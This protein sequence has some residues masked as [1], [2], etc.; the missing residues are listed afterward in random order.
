MKITTVFVTHDQE[1]AL[2]ISD[3]VF[4]MD[5][6][7]LQ[8]IGK[9]MQIYEEPANMFVA[10]FIGTPNINFLEAKISYGHLI[11]QGSQILKI[12]ERIENYDRVILGIR[13]EHLALTKINEHY[14]HLGIGKISLI[15]HLGKINNVK[16]Q[17]GVNELTVLVEPEQLASHQVGDEIMLYFLKNKA[18]LFG[19][20]ENRIQVSYE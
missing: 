1:E 12:K 9:P 17:L 13:P 10:R 7:S 14:Q 5:K 3:K 16:V 2:S 19:Q 20:D 6:G 15:E 11:F 18:Y 4:V 8:Q